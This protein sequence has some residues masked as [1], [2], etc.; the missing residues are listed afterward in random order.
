MEK[1]TVKR[2]V[3]E[4]IEFQL[5]GRSAEEIVCS[6]ATQLK[7]CGEFTNSSAVLN[8]ISMETLVRALY[9]GYEVEKTPKQELVE[10]YRY[11]RKEAYSPDMTAYA[12]G[13]ARAVNTLGISIE[14]VNA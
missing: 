9:V 1:V 12:D 5:M 7:G 6:K 3:A 13:I 10:I 11:Y 8:D 4:A 14:G 2:E